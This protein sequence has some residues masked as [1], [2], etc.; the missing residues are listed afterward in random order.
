MEEITSY[1]EVKIDIGELEGEPF[2]LNLEEIQEVEGRAEKQIMP[3]PKHF[4]FDNSHFKGLLDGFTEGALKNFITISTEKIRLYKVTEDSIQ[5]LS[6]FNTP[7]EIDDIFHLSVIANQLDCS[8]Q[9]FHYTQRTNKSIILRIDPTTG[10]LLSTKE[11]IIYKDP[12]IRCIY[13]PDIV[14]PKT[15]R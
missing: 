3:A 5:L 14:E 11:T 4:S 1:K 7:F 6:C 10:V 13:K 8:L 15:Q 12:N 9:V 2:H